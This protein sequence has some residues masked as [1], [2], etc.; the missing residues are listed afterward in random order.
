MT[1]EFNKNDLASNDKP[2]LLAYARDELGLNI[3]GN[4]NPETIIARI[5]EAN[6][7][8]GTAVN[9]DDQVDAAGA[10]VQSTAGPTD[11]D[12]MDD[13]EID[14]EG[15]GTYDPKL[16]AKLPPLHSRKRHQMVEVMITKEKGD[17]GSMDVP[18]NV[19]GKQYLLKRGAWAT[20][21]YFIVEVLKNAEQTQYEERIVNGERVQ[22]ANDVPSYP[23]QVRGLS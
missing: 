16:K 14:W 1:Q 10:V 15:S 3:P 11:G 12:E 18:I 13:D 2:A 6:G 19:Q 5:N 21:P 7:V 9:P 4:S 17:T 23:F 22:E 8:S 20:V